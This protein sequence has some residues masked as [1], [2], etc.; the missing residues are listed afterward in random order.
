MSEK[1]INVVLNHGDI[2][3]QGLIALIILIGNEDFYLNVDVTRHHTSRSNSGCSTSSGFS[4]ANSCVTE[5][6]KM[7]RVVDHDTDKAKP[8]IVDEWVFVFD[9][10]GRE[11]MGGVKD[12]RIVVDKY[13]KTTGHKIIILKND[14]TRFNAKCAEN[15][16]GWRIHFRSVNGNISRFV[17]KD[18]NVIHRLLSGTLL[19]VGF[20]WK[21]HILAWLKS[22]AVK[23]KLVKH[24]IADNIQ[25]DP[26]LKPNH[27]MSL[28]KKIYGSNIKY[29]HA[30]RGKEAVFEEQFGDDEK[31]YSGL[32]WY[33]QA[34]EQTNSDIYVKF[35]FDHATRRFQ[36]IF[37]CFG[38][39]K[40]IYRYKGALM[41]AT[42]INGNNEFYPFAFALVSTE[43]KDNWFWFLEN[44][45]QVV[46]D[47]QIVFLSD[48]G[49]GLLQGIPIFFP[50][51]YHNYFFYHIK[52]NLPIGS[53]DANS[54]SFIDLFYK[55]A[56]SYTTT[57]FEEALRGMHA[58]ECGHVA[59]YIRTIPKKKWENAFFPIC[60]YSAHSSTLAESFNNW[61]LDFKKLSAF[62]LLD[63]IQTY[64]EIIFPI[65]NN[66]KPRAYDPNDRVIV[67]NLVPPPGKRR[68]QRIKNAW[69]NQMRPMMCTKCFTLGHHD[70]AT[71]PMI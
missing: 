16:C 34:I 62:A 59:N 56:Y 22:H 36:R 39:C 11:L 12:V 32:T 27:I 38:A 58:I 30:R 67:P 2:Q 4:T 26:S 10:V 42:C 51:S 47:R 52:C 37:I 48:R 6:P 69:E 50:N 68:T 54:N 44:L 40:H 15:D 8:L 45:K 21:L 19:V 7:V 64:Q 20:L 41:D 28:F 3:L 65:T 57:N 70:R 1:F 14:K 13:K 63:A 17:L 61:I 43:N 60:R 18:S 29:H 66:E 5:S 49:E 9:K 25:G 55:A 35:E 31:S 53:G 33:V 24:L 71:C 46:D 23:T